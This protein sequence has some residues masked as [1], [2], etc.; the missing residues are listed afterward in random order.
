MAECSSSAAALDIC[1][2]GSYL[3]DD[4]CYRTA[5]T[6]HCGFH[7]INNLPQL[8]KDVLLWRCGIQDANNTSVPISDAMN[9]CFHH[10]QVF[11]VKYAFLQR[12]CYDPFRIHKKSV[13]CSLREADIPTVQ[14]V[15][16]KTVLKP[17]GYISEK[18]HPS[19]GRRK[20][21]EAE[22]A[23]KRKVQAAFEIPEKRINQRL[24]QARKF[25]ETKGVL[26][27]IEQCRVGKVVPTAIKND[28]LSFYE[29]D[30]NSI[31]CPSKNDCVSVTI[32][33]LY[34]SFKKQ[35]PDVKV[36]ISKFFDLRPKSVVPVSAT[37]T[38][39]VC[40]CQI[41]QNAKPMLSALPLLC[42]DHKEAMITI[43]RDIHDSNGFLFATSHG[44]NMCDGIGGTAKRLAA[45]ASLKRPM[46]GHILTHKL[47]AWVQAKTVAGTRRHHFFS[48]VNC[49]EPNMSRL[50]SPNYRYETIVIVDSIK[51]AI[52]FNSDSVQPG[53]CVA[54][55]Y[56][57]KLYLGYV[58]QCSPEEGDVL[59]NSMRPAGPSRSFS[60]PQSKDEVKTVRDKVSTFENNLRKKSLLLPAYILT[61]A[62]SDMRPVKLVTMDG[63]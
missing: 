37:G 12:T 41:H 26:P 52:H 36:G 43:V 54:V 7:V 48:P 44:K 19:C 18:N 40:V 51:R 22:E 39:N 16:L 42:L 49:C 27:D 58:V 10:F 25:K 60:W 59:L 1:S 13:K 15:K 57:S 53:C 4:A 11:C 45:R 8:Q 47:F 3:Q 28:V 6:K 29:D 30:E 38:H 2:I 62:L 63:N 21:K 14:K 20:L 24:R 61:A 9:I 17:P 34:T 55:A 5:Y 50:S 33:E 35:N 32:D 23:V 31:S 46:D 56:E